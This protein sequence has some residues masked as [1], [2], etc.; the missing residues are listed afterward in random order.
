[1]STKQCIILSGVGIIS[2]LGVIILGSCVK[3][4]VDAVLK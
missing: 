1:M 4:V 2:G 3:H